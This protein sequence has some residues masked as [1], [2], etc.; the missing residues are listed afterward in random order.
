MKKLLNVSAANLV[1]GRGPPLRHLL[2]DSVS[3]ALI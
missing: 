3:S 2:R 1:A